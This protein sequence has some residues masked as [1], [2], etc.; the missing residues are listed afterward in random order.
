MVTKYLIAILFFFSCTTNEA[1][2]DTPTS[3]ETESNCQTDKQG[4]YSCLIT[5]KTVSSRSIAVQAG[6][7]GTDCSSVPVLPGLSPVNHD[8][9]T[10]LNDGFQFGETTHTDVLI[11]LATNQYAQAVN[12]RYPTPQNFRR[13]IDFV[14]PPTNYNKANQTTVSVSSCPGDFSTSAACVKVVAP[15]TS[16]RFS[17][18]PNDSASIYCILEPGET[19]YFN[20]VHSPDPYNQSPSCLSSSDNECALFFTETPSN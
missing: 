1:C 7:G 8:Y 2:A 6:S 13:R 11:N 15:F 12:F 18:N 19:Y 10:D 20:V 3:S 4:S 14:S 17:N 5:V 16:M 9:V